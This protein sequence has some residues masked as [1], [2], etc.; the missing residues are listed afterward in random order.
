MNKFIVGDVLT[1]LQKLPDDLVDIAV[2]SPP[3]NKQENKKGWLV[4]NVKYDVANDK[5]DENDYQENQINVLNEVFRIMKAG[6]SFFYNH[7]TRWEKGEM[8]HPMSW[9]LKT[10]WVIR[11]E[12]I[13]DRTIAA[14]IR[15]WR[16]WQ[17]DE[18]IYW[19]YKPLDGKNKIGTELLS[20]HALMTSIWRF[21]PEGKNPHPAPFPLALPLRCISSIL[22]DKDGL[23][24]D[25]Y[26]GSGT[27]CLA[28][29]LLGKKYIGIDISPEYTEL[30][31][32][33]LQ[34]SD[35]ELKNLELEMEKHTVKKTFKERKEEGKWKNKDKTIKLI[36]RST[37]KLIVDQ[38]LKLI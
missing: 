1:E 24:L 21:T 31:K 26:S 3:Y 27:T 35:T 37:D 16:F 29:K 2:T 30:A 34:N 32:T 10:N 33:R 28:A 19:L 14:N 8:I 7:K 23:V 12:I 13:W 18:R 17:V 11:Q 6:G 20:K 22:D 4:K 36:N 15:G 9:L 38:Q 25:P 5:L